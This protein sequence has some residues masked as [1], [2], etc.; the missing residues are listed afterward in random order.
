MAR[1][2]SSL[3]VPVSP[4]MSTGAS[5]AA[6]RPISFQMASIAVDVPT[7]PA[8]AG[9]GGG[10]VSACDSAALLDRALDGGEERREIE[11][12]GQVVEGAVAHGAD[13]ALAVAVR[14]RHDDRH[15]A[16]RAGADLAQELEPVAVA[17]A[18][19][20]QHAVGRARGQL[21]ARLGEA[22][23]GRAR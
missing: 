22:G 23:R 6:A 17:Q 5:E 3:P 20:E 4:V 12:L 11:R 19:V 15:V 2:T 13:G 7:R 18:D 16:L 21:A 9:G 10:L 1:A 8:R 14:R